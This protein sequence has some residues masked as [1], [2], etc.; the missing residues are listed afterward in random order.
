MTKTNTQAKT[1]APKGVEAAIDQAVHTF[2]QIAHDNDT[3]E[4][5]KES[6]G[7]QANA[8]VTTTRDADS[9][10]TTPAHFFE[11]VWEVM[12][13]NTKAF[14]AVT[15]KTIV[16]ERANGKAPA[17]MSVYRS[18]IVKAW[19]NNKRTMVGIQ[20]F[21]DV[22]RL[23]NPKSPLEEELTQALKNVG[24]AARKATKKNESFARYAIDAMN[25]LV[26]ELNQ[27]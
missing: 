6:K 5:A 8:L 17:T 7:D 18:K 1:K 2:V 14:D 20:D 13:Y 16:I 22:T 24:Q 25:K 26:S 12:G 11:K 27:E 3:M 19:D 9:L 15:Q 23:V 4:T 10:G 21:K